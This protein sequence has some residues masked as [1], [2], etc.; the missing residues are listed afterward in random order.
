MLSPKARNLSTS[1]VRMTTSTV[2]AQLLTIS[3][4]A[5]AEQLTSVLPTGNVEP[6][7]GAHVLFV[8][9]PKPGTIGSGNVT[10]NGSPSSDR[11]LIGEGHDIGVAKPGPSTC[12]MDDGVVGESLPQAT[13][14][15]PK[16]ETSAPA[17]KRPSPPT[18][19]KGKQRL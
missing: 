15:A 11:I 1:K 12:T 5:A 10:A 3:S 18:L 8:T 13:K 7:S 17:N 19:T 4:P 2:N 16:S 6:D 14:P 9:S